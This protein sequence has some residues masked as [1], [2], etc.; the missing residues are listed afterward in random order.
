MK[1]SELIKDLNK[2]IKQYGDL[3][4]ELHCTCSDPCNLNEVR[5]TS[6]TVYG[7]HPDKQDKKCFTLLD[8]VQWSR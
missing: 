5:K 2:L 6:Y 4:V 1:A 7:K 8:F 3:P